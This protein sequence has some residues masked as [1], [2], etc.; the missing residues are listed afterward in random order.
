MYFFIYDFIRWTQSATFIEIFIYLAIHCYV[1]Y[2]LQVIAKKTNEEQVW[3]AWFPILNIILMLMIAEEPW[4]F[5]F[6][7]MVPLI[8]LLIVLLVLI[9]IVRL[10]GRSGWYVLLFFVPIINLIAWGNLA[11][12]EAKAFRDMPASSGYKPAPQKSRFQDDHWMDR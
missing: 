4:Q 9:K 12:K 2:S 1:A 3:M 11:F 5:Y 6:L 10:R 7:L 8:N